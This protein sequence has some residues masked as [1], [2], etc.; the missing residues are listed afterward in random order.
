VNKICPAPIAGN[1]VL[2]NPSLFT[3]YIALKPAELAVDIFPPGVL[4]VPGGDD[5][6]GTW[7][8]QHPDNQKVT[9]TGSV[10]TG[11]LVAAACAQT[12]RLVP[13]TSARTM[14]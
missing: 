14:C 6:R 8:T 1:S 9:S 12:L 13:L 4:Q 10:A 11:K 2:V 5:K 3:Q 7:M